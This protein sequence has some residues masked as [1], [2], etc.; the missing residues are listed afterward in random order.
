MQA[1]EFAAGLLT[2][3][4]GAEPVFTEEEMNGFIESYIQK[5]AD[6]YR[7][8]LDALAEANLGEAE[9]FLEDN[10]KRPEV[11]IL[12]SVFRLNTHTMTRQTVLPLLIQTL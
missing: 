8:W 5:L 1:P 10:A 7:A 3:L 4:Y 2:A 12:P 6:D 11:T 9:T